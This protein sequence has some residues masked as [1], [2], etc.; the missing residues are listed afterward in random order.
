MLRSL[1]LISF[2]LYDLEDHRLGIAAQAALS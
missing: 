2:V 1:S